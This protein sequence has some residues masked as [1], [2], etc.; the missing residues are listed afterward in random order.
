MAGA[1]AGGLREGCTPP[2]S[3][4]RARWTAGGR[5][6]VGALRSGGSASGTGI[7]SILAG[8][9][10]GGFGGDTA[11]LQAAIG[12]AKAHG[13]GTI[14]VGSSESS[15]ASVILSSGANVGARR[16]LGSREYGDGGVP[17]G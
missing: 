9:G 12:Y 10:A 3:G 2:G 15:A 8:G 14:G 17:G 16:V 11:T 6:G 13:G 7:R 5:L 4:R 1:A